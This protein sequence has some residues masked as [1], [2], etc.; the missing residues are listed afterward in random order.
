MR[1]RTIAAMAGSAALV[2][3]T[4]LA[5]LSSMPERQTFDEDQLAALFDPA[6]VARQSCGNGTAEMFKPLTQFVATAQAGVDT[7]D[8]PRLWDNLG[9]LSFPVSTID[10]SAQRYFDQG[11]RLTYAF[12]HAE[13]R[14]SFRHAQRLDPLCAM[15]YWGEALVLGPNINAG[16]NSD[17]A[18]AAVAAITTA[19][20]LTQ[21]TKPHETALIEALA[22]RYATAPDADRTELDRT[23]ADAMAA[24]AERFTDND[25]IAVLAAESLMNL[26]PWDYWQADGT[27]PKGR[28]GEVVTLLERVLDRN[29]E[30]PGAIHFYI[31][32]TEASATPERAEPYADR[33]AALMPGAGHLVHMPSHTYYRIG[34]YIDSLNANVAAVKADEAYLETAESYVVSYA[35]TYYPHNVHFVVQSAQLAGAPEI[36]LTYAAKLERVLDEETMRT[37]PWVQVIRVAPF[38]A[39]VQFSD[40]ATVLALADPGDELPYVKAMWHYA[41]AVAFA[42]AGQIAGA[43]K[44][45]SELAAIGRAND[46][47]DMVAG[48][49]PAPELLRLA[50]HVID[51]RVAM[52][53]GDVD[54]AIA[55]FRQAVTVQDGIAYMEPPYWYYPVRQSLGA[56]LL[57]AGHPEEAAETFR[58]SL[59]ETPNNG[60]ALWGLMQAKRRMGDT[61]A[62]H[63]I[64]RVF[65]RVW[66]GGADDLDL[67]R[68]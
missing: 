51:G 29:P 6:A 8:P 57:A 64:G 31:H 61:V 25:D 16:M 67:A 32:I 52:A 18:G 3:S 43:R 13:A 2:A 1:I 26:S 39:H 5:T 47:A 34:R 42:A 41:R 59:V 24:A 19:Q 22:L 65:S 23:Y 33:L 7:V 56:A 38:F 49:V 21:R 15:C 20:A 17:G 9:D 10:A 40:P 60:W 46:F 54:S 55:A 14:R 58:R 63:H 36:A 30:H 53:Q 28:T 27:T 50:W 4:G 48:G 62:A 44:E 11:L 37:I 35:G 68:L 45:A 12:N 66:A